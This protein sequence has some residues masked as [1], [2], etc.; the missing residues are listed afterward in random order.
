M[1]SSTR[2]VQSFIHTPHHGLNKKKHQHTH[3][4]EEAEKDVHLLHPQTRDTP[5]GY[6]ADAFRA[7]IKAGFPGTAHRSQKKSEY[8]H[9]LLPVVSSPLVDLS[10]VERERERV[11]RDLK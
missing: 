6:P 8:P 2:R 1:M 3:K 10:T 9:K 5:A 11:H 4:K 7:F